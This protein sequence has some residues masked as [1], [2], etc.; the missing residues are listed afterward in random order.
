MKEILFATTNKGKLAEL[1]VL[2]DG[3]P[4]R[5]LSLRDVTPIHV[6]EDAEDFAGNAA[7]KALA[8][9]NALG[10][11]AMGDDTGLC[12]DALNGAPGIYSAR[13]GGVAEGVLDDAAARYAAN[14]A[15]LLKELDGV[16][17]GRR[18]AHFITDI[19]IAIPGRAPMHFEGRVDGTILTSPRGENG[20]GY[21]PLFFV[22][23]LGRTMAEV[24][25]AEK[26]RISHRG[27][28]FAKLRPFLMEWSR[29]V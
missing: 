20:F 27:R 26:T 22:P 4:I 24:S 29:E 16:P 10:V 9:S 28:A 18:S 2:V 6:E 14:N 19:C 17:E 7:K 21:D 8:Y 11:P 5:V 12:V 23:E 1:E 25:R 15:R 3:L 13:Y